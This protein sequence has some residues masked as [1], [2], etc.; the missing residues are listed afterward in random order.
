MRPALTAIVVGICAAASP[1]ATNTVDQWF[2]QA[3]GLSDKPG[4][5]T[6]QHISTPDYLCG[7]TFATMCKDPNGGSNVLMLSFWDLY[8]YDR[9]HH[10]GLARSGTDQLGWALFTAPPPPGVSVPDKDLS[11]YATGRGL[12]IGSPYSQV[13]ALYGPPVMHGKHFVTSYGADD[14]VYYKG[15]PQYWQGKLERQSETIT[16]VVDDGR[17][18]S[19]TINVELWEP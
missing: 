8:S 15:K 2:S 1:A 5:V 18:S 3:T 7:K 4:P 13:L 6:V 10:I 11:H 14:T 12:H 9:S 19:I 16:L 17:V